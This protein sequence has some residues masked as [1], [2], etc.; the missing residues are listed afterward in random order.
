M[1]QMGRNDDDDGEYTHGYRLAI[2]SERG[3]LL[4]TF[5]GQVETLTFTVR[6]ALALSKYLLEGSLLL[7]GEGEVL[8]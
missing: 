5:D 2:D 3:L 6:E 8:Q 7:M 4:V 1:M